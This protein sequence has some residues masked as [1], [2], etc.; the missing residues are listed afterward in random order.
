MSYTYNT[1]GQVKSRVIHKYLDSKKKQQETY[2]QYFPDG[3]KSQEVYDYDNNGDMVEKTLFVQDKMKSLTRYKYFI[4]QL[5]SEI[6][7]DADG[8]CCPPDKPLIDADGKCWACEDEQHPAVRM[9]WNGANEVSQTAIDRCAKCDNRKLMVAVKGWTHCSI[10]CPEGQIWGTDGK[11]HDCDEPDLFDAPHSEC[12][13]CPNRFVGN[14]INCDC[15][16]YHC[17]DTR[18]IKHSYFSTPETYATCQKC[19]G[20]I[21]VDGNCTWPCPTDK[22]V[23][24]SKGE[25]HTCDEAV[26]SIPIA[27][28]TWEEC[29][30]CDGIRFIADTVNWPNSCRRC[31]DEAQSIKAGG[32][33][34]PEW[35]FLTCNGCPNRRLVNAYCAKPCT[36]GK[37]WDNVGQCHTCDEEADFNVQGVPENKCACPGVQYLDG[38]I[39]K[40]CP[41]DLSALTPEQK[42]ACQNSP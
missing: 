9:E 10:P 32:T 14:T 13:K 4:H 31:D 34:R 33:W 3:K 7:Y 37:I 12:F 20:R 21:Q 1:T 29:L 11:C 41:E 19:P 25:C 15:G 22:P 17:S 24:S 39:C 30:K 26:S 6:T 8:N 5:K 18:S 16:C 27:Q 28:D 36:D 23:M 42:V 38:D 40:K 35:M 2:Y